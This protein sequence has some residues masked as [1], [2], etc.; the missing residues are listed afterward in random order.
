MKKFIIMAIAILM[1][2]SVFQIAKAAPAE[3]GTSATISTAKGAVVELNDIVIRKMG[4][5]VNFRVRVKNIGTLPAKNLKNNMVI[6]LRVKDTATGNWRELQQWSNID[7]IKAGQTIARDRTPVKSMDPA[8]L[9]GNFTLQA[10]IVIKTPGNVTI[11]RAIL[12]KSY[13]QDGVKNP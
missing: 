2:A 9:S 10:E 7:V 6:Y 11:S 12:E 8:V 5:E 13:P 4:D 1:L 3:P